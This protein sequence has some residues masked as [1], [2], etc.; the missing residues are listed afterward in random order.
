M[1]G[2]YAYPSRGA[3]RALIGAPPTRSRV[4]ASASMGGVKDG[5]DDTLRALRAPLPVA[6]V[7]CRS[8]VGLVMGRVGCADGCGRFPR[9]GDAMSH[10]AV[11]AFAFGVSMATF[12]LW[13]VPSAGAQAFPPPP[14][15]SPLVTQ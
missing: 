3:G 1:N 10:R 9:G 7:R 14:A 13:L 2:G 5:A 11:V 12:S 15:F 8:R 6:L 4:A